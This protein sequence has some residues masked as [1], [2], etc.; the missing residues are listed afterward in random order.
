MCDPC[1]RAKSTKYVRRKKAR[2]SNVSQSNVDDFDAPVM[3]DDE[4]D[5]DDDNDVLDVDA[6]EVPVGYPRDIAKAQPVTNTITC[7][8]TDLKGP[9]ATAGLKGEVYAQSYIEERTK[10]LR[11]YYFTN[12]SCGQPEGPHRVETQG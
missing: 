5:D 2:L 8:F 6:V 10:Y 11:R 12:K 9:F 7:M 1:V 3:Y 4:Y